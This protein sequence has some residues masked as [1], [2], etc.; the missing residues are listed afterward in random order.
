M[1]H[2]KQRWL[3]FRAIQGIF[4]YCTET[5][6][7]IENHAGASILLPNLE[8]ESTMTTRAKLIRP[9]NITV[10]K[11]KHDAIWFGKDM[12]ENGLFKQNADLPTGFGIRVRR[13]D[14]GSIVSGWLVQY[15][16]DGH[17][18]RMGIG[19]G[20]LLSP[21][22]ALDK[23]KKLLSQVALGGDPGRDKAERR[24][25]DALSLLSVIKQFLDYK[26]TDDIKKATMRGLENYLEGPLGFRAKAVGMKPY[27]DGLH[28]MAIDRVG[29]K[30]I[31]ARLLSVH[32]ESGAPT[33]IALRS[34]LQGMFVW[35]MQMGLVESNPVID[36]FKPPRAPSRERVLTDAEL[37]A[38][39][40]TVKYEYGTVIKLLVLTG[41][42]RSEIA[43]MRW[44]EF[45]WDK[46][47][48]TLP[49]ERSKTGKP[50]TLPITP[51]MEEIIATVPHRDGIDLLFGR[52]HGYTGWSIGKREL[53]AKL[54]LPAWVHHDIRRSVATGMGDNLGILPHVVEAVL[55]H[56]SGTKRG[57]AGI[58]N[59]SPYEKEVATAMAMWSNHIR[60]LVEG[61]ERKVVPM[62][63]H[64]RKA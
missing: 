17:T 22:Q 34:A 41:C 47:A 16:A 25:K 38:I 51:L 6:I 45:D 49:K 48:W 42:R 29:R 4:H 21:S 55:N 36:A 54:K 33:A 50:H 28:R 32:K 56:Q 61:G 43:G 1:V 63:I 3:C 59:R 58:Y 26:R 27:L 8:R 31:A 52:K 37:T 9:Q 18:R 60:T 24:Q 5:G 19:K 13:K 20:S 39:W 12:K 23:A 62:P 46:G 14:D 10:L 30:E 15:R 35:A 11:G 40:K 44:P 7:A 64:T 53:D 57:V 2:W